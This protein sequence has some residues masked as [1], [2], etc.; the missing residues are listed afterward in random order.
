MLF[1]GAFSREQIGG[2]CIY[3]EGTIARPA[4]RWDDRVRWGGW[5]AM[6]ASGRPLFLDCER[7]GGTVEPAVGARGGQLIHSGLS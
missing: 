7:P 5:G 6:G 2:N 1:D 3:Q 4:V